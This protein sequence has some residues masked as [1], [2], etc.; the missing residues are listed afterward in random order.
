M[1]KHTLS[2]RTRRFKRISVA[3]GILSL[4]TSIGPLAVFG[5]MA[6]ASATPTQKITI[7]FMA[8]AAIIIAAVN[9]LMKAHARSPF[10]IAVLALVWILDQIAPVIVLMAV[11]SLLDELLLSPL[12]KWAKQRYTIGKEIDIRG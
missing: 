8:T 7:S 11:C 4:V 3:M 1:R 10:W 6:W 9:I 12:H 5:V 2:S